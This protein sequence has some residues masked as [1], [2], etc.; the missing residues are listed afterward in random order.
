MVSRVLQTYLKGNSLS[1]DGAKSEKQKIIC[2][3]P[4]GSVLGPLLFLIFIKN[5]LMPLNF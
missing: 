5:L 2:G 3:V 4:Q 1:A